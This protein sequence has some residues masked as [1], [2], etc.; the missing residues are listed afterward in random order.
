MAF[1]KGRSGSGAAGVRRVEADVLVIGGGP[2]GCWAALAAAGSGARVLLVDKGYCGTSGAA[3]AAGHDVWYCPPDPELREEAM[4]SREGLGG[5]LADR[6]WSSRVLDESDRQ[7]NQLADWGYP[8]PEGHEFRRVSKDGHVHHSRGL[9]GPAYMRIMRRKVVN[10]RVTV[11]DHSPVL[12][13]LRTRDGEV[14]G[15]TGVSRQRDARWEVRARAVVV[16]T[17]G[18]TFLSGGLGCNV[19]TGAGH[20]AA[21]EAGAELSGMEF[22]SAYAIAPAFAS[23][24]KTAYYQ[25]ATFTRTRT[26]RSCP[27]PGGTA[28][29]RSPG[30]PPGRRSSP[31]S[32]S[33][34]PPE[35]GDPP[36]C[37]PQ[38]GYA[39]LRNATWEGVQVKRRGGG[40]RGCGGAW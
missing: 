26:A 22:S 30:A 11:W 4:A 23:V 2:A 37:V 13:L 16:A 34:R 6:T 18:C 27:A 25:Y 5:W 29:R 28:A 17:G 24:T 33:R 31:S 39:G 32:G 40:G 36:S 19:L 10:A 35:P 21:A 3:A 15:A 12:E 7:V 9:Q 8:F 20:L 1:T 38:T 14:V